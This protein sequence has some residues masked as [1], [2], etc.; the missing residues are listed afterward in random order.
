MMMMVL[1][2]WDCSLVRESENMEEHMG[3]QKAQGN[4]PKMA[5]IQVGKQAS[6]RTGSSPV[7]I[8]I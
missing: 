3:V 6:M 1:I 8:D 4:H 2:V 7:M 5:S